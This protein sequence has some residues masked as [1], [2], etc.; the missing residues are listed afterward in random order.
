VDEVSFELSAAGEDFS[1]GLK[2]IKIEVNGTELPHLVRD[3][4]LPGAR[5]EGDEELA[6]NYVGLVPGYVRMDVAGHFLAGAGAKLYDTDEEKVQLLGCGCG[7]IGCSPLLARVTVTDDTV[8]WDD[9]EQ[10]TR[11]EWDYD[12]LGPFTFERS[13]YERALFALLE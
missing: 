5:A 4:E 8:T 12:D 9:F 10:P 13:Q 3:V 2:Q 6:G 1:E 7:E 11:P